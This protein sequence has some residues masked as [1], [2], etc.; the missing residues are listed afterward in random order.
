[1]TKSLATWVFWLCLATA[2]TALRWDNSDR[3]YFLGD[4][5]LVANL[6]DT[7]VHTGD[8][9]P[10]W[11][12]VQ[13]A[14]APHAFFEQEVQRTDV[15]HDHHFNF[16]TH[17]LISAGMLKLVRDWSIDMPTATLLHHIA[18]F[19]DTVSLLCILAAGR[20]LG[21]STLAGI[22]AV[23]YTVF[24]LAVQGSHYARP[25]AFLTALASALTLLALVR[26]RL[27]SAHWAIGN[28][29]ILALA[30]VCKPSQ[31]LLSLLPGS[32]WLSAWIATA[33][34]K[35]C[36]LHIFL[37]GIL[38]TSTLLLC[39]VALFQFAKIGWQDFADSVRTIS[40]YYFHPAPPDSLEHFS[41]LIQLQNISHYALTTLGIP[42]LLA[43]MT[44]GYLVAI[45]LPTAAWVLIMPVVA[46][47]AYYS[48]IP[49]FF[50]RSFCVLSANLV[51]LAAYAIHA[52]ITSIVTLR[53]RIAAAVLLSLVIGYTPA[54]INYHLQTDH[55]RHHHGEDR[56][57]FQNQLK[58][59]WPGFWLKPVN[60]GDIFG[61][62]LPSKPATMPRIYVVED[63]NDWNSRDYAQQ[64]RD[65]GFVQIAEFTG[66]FASIPTS[67]LLTVHEAARFRYFIRR[68]EWPADKPLPPAS[69]NNNK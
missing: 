9:Q 46:L 32:A 37:E 25:D 39:T 33:N 4:D 68:D 34:R 12:R 45:R 6:C 27:P 61:R 24:P 15:A 16:T 48:T 3:L 66:D 47:V 8:W 43:V 20:Q 10:D 60:R 35:N 22:A 13:P 11:R 26:H 40:A 41:W 67:S 62:T 29:G 63:F 58:S 53:W 2:F 23:L 42:F 51:L 59:Q 36:S 14:N 65:N 49:T 56:R 64:L 38:L 30:V 54:V 19:W 5:N 7:I 21:G 50:D 69:I 1:M 18:F 17:I 52:T 28:G 57:L 55:L 31:L 44:G